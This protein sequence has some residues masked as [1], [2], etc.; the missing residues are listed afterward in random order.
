M[1]VDH[2]LEGMEYASMAMT[3]YL[4]SVDIESDNAE[5][6][7]LQLIDTLHP[8][9]MIRWTSLAMVSIAF[10]YIQYTWSKKKF[11]WIPVKCH[12]QSA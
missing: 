7:Y 9:W 1:L 10:G 5:Q 6:Q 11:N 4:T 8:D 12:I 2:E 3:C